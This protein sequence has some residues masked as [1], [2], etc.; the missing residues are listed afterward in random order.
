MHRYPVRYKVAKWSFS[1]SHLTEEER[2]YME[3]LFPDA[4]NFTF[5]HPSKVDARKLITSNCYRSKFSISWFNADKG[6]WSGY[7]FHI[8]EC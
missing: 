6:L 3:S 7:G 2:Q 1:Y 8:I 5:H 4:P